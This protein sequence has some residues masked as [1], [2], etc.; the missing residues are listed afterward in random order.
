MTKAQPRQ[1][2]SARL[3]KAKTIGAP[4]RL[5]LSRRDG[6]RLQT[7]SQRTNGL[8]AV[9]VARPSKW[10][11]PYPVAAYGR[12][13]AIALY[14]DHLRRSIP[15]LGELRGRNL[16]CWCKPGDL[17]HADILLMLANP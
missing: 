13:K 14:E 2:P 1:K 8:E 9:N 4:V 5:Q 17:C 15:D 3:R 10:G 11:N 7:L 16:A 6:F 12:E